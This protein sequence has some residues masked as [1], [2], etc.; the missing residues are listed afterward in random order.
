MPLRSYNRMTQVLSNLHYP[1]KN[2]MLYFIARLMARFFYF[3]SHWPLMP[4][5]YSPA[6][7]RDTNF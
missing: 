3:F 5:T 4:R 7:A 6:G 1:H 2:P